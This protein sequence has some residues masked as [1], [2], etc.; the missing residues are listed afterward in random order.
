MNLAWPSNRCIL[1]RLPASE[2]PEGELTKEHIIPESLGGKLTCYFLCRE[3]NN[4]PSDRNGGALKYEMSV[5]FALFNVRQRLPRIP[6]HDQQE[7]VVRTGAG[8]HKTTGQGIVRKSEQDAGSFLFEENSGENFLRAKLQREGIAAT[9]IAEGLERL[10][11]APYDK[12]I[13]IAGEWAAYRRQLLEF[14]PALAASTLAWRLDGTESPA[15]LL[16]GHGTALLKI[17]Y[18]YIAL[19]AGDLIFDERLQFI[20]DVIRGN[21]PSEFRCSPGNPPWSP[22]DP[23]LHGLALM[24]RKGGGTLVRILLLG[25]CAFDIEFPLLQFGPKF[26]RMAYTLDLGSGREVWTGLSEIAEPEGPASSL[27]T[28]D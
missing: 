18:G 4:Q 13:P 21:D 15:V 7:Y 22:S 5:K 19:F 24:D 23:I 16:P 28:T 12:E 26:Q 8:W 9:P 11:K 17:A 27:H 2:T 1:C 14:W 10:A 20:R 3:C 6:A 25:Q